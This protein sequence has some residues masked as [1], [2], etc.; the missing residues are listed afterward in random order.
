MKKLH[1][2]SLLL[3]FF[4]SVALW[5]VIVCRELVD[6]IIEVRLDYK[7]IP[8]DL[9]VLSGFES[10]ATI[11]VRGPQGLINI[12]KS[13]NDIYTVDL[14]N[15]HAGINKLPL[16][17]P[18]PQ[19]AVTVMS[20]TPPELILKA[21]TLITKTVPISLVSP[22][23]IPQDLTIISTKTPTKTVTLR[24]PKTLLQDITAAPFILHLPSKP[25]IEPISLRLTPQIPAQVESVPASIDVLVELQL[26]TKTITLQKQVEFLQTDTLTQKLSVSPAQVTLIVTAPASMDEKVISES[27][28]V[29][30]QLPQL[31]KSSTVRLPI[32]INTTNAIKVRAIQPNTVTVHVQKE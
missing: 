24:G 5:Y 29:Y 26:T 7:G 31:S 23:N 17:I 8:N 32:R 6:T 22:K 21:D 12:L 13:K 27:I 18:S 15:I 1:L 20:T 2:S 16:L 4:M 30:V 25:S 11:Q 14:S 19:P 28:T 3:A 10:T 9:V